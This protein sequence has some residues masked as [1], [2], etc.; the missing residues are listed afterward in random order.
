MQGAL[1]IMKSYVCVC[2]IMAAQVRI[3]MCRFSKLTDFHAMLA[4]KK[5]AML[6]KCAM[7]CYL[8]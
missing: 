8:Q 3:Q 5:H 7:Q 6:K 2:K 4:K 1:C